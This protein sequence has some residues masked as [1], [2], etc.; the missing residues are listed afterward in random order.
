MVPRQYNKVPAVHRMTKISKCFRVRVVL[1]ALSCCV[2]RFWVKSNQNFY[3]SCGLGASNPFPSPAWDS[4]WTS[5]TPLCFRVA[6]PSLSSPPYSS[7]SFPLHLIQALMVVAPKVV[8]Q[9]AF[10]NKI[11]GTYLC[12]HLKLCARTQIIQPVL[13]QD[14]KVKPNFLSVPAL[15]RKLQKMPQD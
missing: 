2:S 12:L 5:T 15:Y 9:L 8:W 10:R 14:P 7:P 11:P 13:K 4:S 3:C 6:F 1:K